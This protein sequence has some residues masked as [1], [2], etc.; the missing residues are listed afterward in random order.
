[1]KTVTWSQRLFAG[2]CW[3]S[4]MLPV[5]LM[6]FLLFFLLWQSRDSLGVAL[7]FGDTRPW[8]AIFRF[9]PVWDGIWPAC[10]GTFCVICL[11]CCTAIPVGILCGIHLAEYA[12]GPF[13][14]A[15]SFSVDL[16]AGVPS[17]L[18]GLFGFALILFL[19]RVLGADVKTSLLLSGVCMGLLILPYMI[20]ATHTTLAGLP[21]SLRLLGPSLGFTKVQA[22]RHVLLP[23]AGRGIMSGVI[24]GIGRAAEDTAVI[25]LTGVVANAGLPRGLLDKYEALPFYIF[26]TAAE[27]RGPDDLA[28]GFGAALVLLLLTTGLFVAATTLQRTLERRWRGNP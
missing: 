4:A 13:K 21:E 26:T 6:C 2:F 23:A 3:A 18:M 11:A 14:S 25:M 28:R 19:R 22:I 5:G 9:A 27:Y 24:L 16:L 20:N 17:I 10:V 8:D 15:L 7:F 1:M 12:R